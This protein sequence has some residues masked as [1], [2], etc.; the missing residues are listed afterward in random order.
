VMERTLPI[1]IGLYNLDPRGLR[2]I[3]IR[4]FKNTLASSIKSYL[5]TH[6]HDSAWR[7]NF[8]ITIGSYWAQVEEA[9]TGEYY[10]AHTIIYY[11]R[12]CEDQAY[13]EGICELL[14]G[15]YSES[16][17]GFVSSEG[18]GSSFDKLTL[19]GEGQKMRTRERHEQILETEWADVYQEVLGENKELMIKYETFFEELR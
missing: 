15:T 17:M 16:R 11:D 1:N 18:A 2:T 19:Q 9:I 5:G 14:G 8:K 13:R 10:D 7:E 4:D 3:V 12:F 6:G